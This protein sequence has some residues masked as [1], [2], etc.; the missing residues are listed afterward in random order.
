MTISNRSQTTSTK[1]DILP[2]YETG[3]H[4]IKHQSPTSI[5]CVKKHSKIKESSLILN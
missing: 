3:V 1:H 4:T 5:S 2:K